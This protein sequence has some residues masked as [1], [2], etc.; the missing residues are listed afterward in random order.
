MISHFPLLKIQIQCFKIRMF[1]GEI[2]PKYPPFFVVGV[3]PPKISKHFALCWLMDPELRP[4]PE[5][6]L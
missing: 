4:P 3:S 2:S 6:T 1:H 5:S